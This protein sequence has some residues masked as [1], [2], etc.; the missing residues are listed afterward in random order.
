M[1]NLLFLVSI[2][3]ILATGVNS[4]DEGDWVDTFNLPTGLLL[5]PFYA[6]Y[7]NLTTT[8]AFYYTLFLSEN[9]PSR[10]PLVVRVSAGPGCSG[11]Y[12]MMHGKGPFGFLTNSTEFKLNQWSWNKKANTLFIEG[13]AGVGFSTSDDSTLQNDA[14][15]VYDYLKAIERFYEKFPEMKNNGMYLTGEQYAGVILPF[16][17]KEIVEMNA[18]S[19]T[20]ASLKIPLKGLLLENPC[21]LPEECERDFGFSKFSMRFLRNHYFIT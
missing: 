5:N 21:T 19:S 14:Q 15:T 6:G 1:K 18:R 8:K 17:A 11:H 7:L 9:N 12:G 10:D 4:A 3:V 20:P 13:P 16:L 2:I